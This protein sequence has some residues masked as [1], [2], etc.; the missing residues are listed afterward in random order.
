[1]FN[2]QPT[3]TVI[4]RRSA[5][6]ADALPPGQRSD[7]VQQTGITILNQSSENR[8]PGAD[9]RRQCL[10]SATLRSMLQIKLAVSPSDR[11]L[12]PGR[13][14]QPLIQQRQASG[15]AVTRASSTHFEVAAMTFLPPPPPPSSSSS[16]FPSSPP[17]PPPS[18]SFSS[19]PPPPPSSSSSSPPPSSSSSSS[20]FFFFFFFFCV[21]S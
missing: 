8:I 19:P 21:P 13:Q 17:P 14:V 16:S 18:S 15:R 6:E 5:L 11:K 4:S 1:M 12:T 7:P 20:S 3:G 2:A 9:L 10:R